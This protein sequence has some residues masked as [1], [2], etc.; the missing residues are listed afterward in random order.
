M[1]LQRFHDADDDALVDL[2]EASVPWALPKVRGGTPCGA[3]ASLKRARRGEGRRR[4]PGTAR[5]SGTGSGHP[6]PTQTDLLAWMVVLARF[7]QV[8]D[9]IIRESHLDTLAEAAL[10]PKH[11]RALLALLKFTRELIHQ[12]ASRGSYPSV[13]VRRPRLPS[14]PRG[15]HRRSRTQ[16]SD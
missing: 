2:A 9:R 11:R 3:S 1:L 14:P 6:P 8:F 15:K 4:S 7:H 16:P 13:P 10:Q 12:S 5:G